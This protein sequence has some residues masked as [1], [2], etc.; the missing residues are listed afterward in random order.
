MKMINVTE[1][2]KKVKYHFNN[3]SFYKNKNIYKKNILL[4]K[5][6]DRCL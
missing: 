3:S 6:C 5:L 2:N 1:I 4:P